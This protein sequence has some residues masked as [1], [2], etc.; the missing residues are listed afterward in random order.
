MGRYGSSQLPDAVANPGGLLTPITNYQALGTLE[1]HV[2]KLDVYLNYGA[3]YDARTAFVSGGKGEGYGSPL[4]NNSGCDTETVPGGTS[5][6]VVTPA[7]TPGGATGTSSIPVPGSIGT[8]LTGG[9]NPGGLKNCNGD[10]RV[11]MEGT[12]GFWYRFYKGP[13]GTLQWGPQYSYFDR[14]IWAGTGGGPNATENILLTSF[15]Y[16]LP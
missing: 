8:P 11:I 2:K 12:I 1:Y 10:T 3:E 15:R 9:Y 6:S 16:Y 13:K 5:T 14:N 4:F 7:T